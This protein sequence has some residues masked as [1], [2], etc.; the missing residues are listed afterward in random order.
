MG[1]KGTGVQCAFCHSVSEVVLGRKPS[2]FILGDLSTMY[3]PLA[4]VESPAHD[5][6]QSPI[7]TNSQLCAGCHEYTNDAGVSILSTYTEWKT[8]GLP[9]KNI[10]CQSC[11]MKE[12][13]GAIVDPKVKRVKS[14]QVNLHRFE[15][16]HSADQLHNAV[17]LKID[18]IKQ[19]GDELVVAFTITNS[20]AGHSFPTGMPSR[21]VIARVNIEP[22][23]GDPR[24]QKEVVFERVLVD[25]QGNP[26]QRASEFFQKAALIQL[27]SRL[28]AGESRQVTL[29]LPFKS[30][31][32]GNLTVRLIYM[33]DP[34]P[35]KLEPFQNTFYSFS[36]ILTPR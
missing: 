28:K 16:G 9:E 21:K 34:A 5:T 1:E 27:D 25:K 10:H 18:E 7:F 35:G 17:K 26:V 14:A 29:K 20:G 24:I 3:G 32:G 13:S 36:R 12:V 31:Q 15:G 6:K 2:P 33:D 11:H 22:A 4:E 8:T 19:E 23:N 30:T